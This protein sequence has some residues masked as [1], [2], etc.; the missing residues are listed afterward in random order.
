MNAQPPARRERELEMVIPR[1]CPAGNPTLTSV[2]TSQLPTQLAVIELSTPTNSQ[3]R[4]SV[5]NSKK[6][7]EATTYNV[8]HINAYTV[9]TRV[10]YMH[11][12]TH[13]HIKQ[14]HIKH[15][16]LLTNIRIIPL[17]HTFRLRAK[18]EPMHC[19]NVRS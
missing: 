11:A 1:G 12:C 9:Y 2:Y 14:M 19:L 3:R 6:T 13:M 18:S 15:V 8:P 17:S 4:T 16:H 7:Y 5:G 10:I